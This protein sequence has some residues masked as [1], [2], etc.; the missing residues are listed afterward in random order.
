MMGEDLLQWEHYPN[1]LS[2]FHPKN[3]THAEICVTVGHIQGVK[4]KM[5]PAKWANAAKWIMQYLTCEGQHGSLMGHHLK[6]LI[7]LRY[8]S[9]TSC[10]ISKFLFQNLHKMARKVRKT[11]KDK[12][13]I[14]KHHGLVTL[15]CQEYF[16]QQ[17]NG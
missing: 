17:E 12:L 14:L 9:Y 13:S 6:L 4:R 7:Y 15:L 10:N 8:D 2:K 11:K 5:L 3:E 16:L 1:L